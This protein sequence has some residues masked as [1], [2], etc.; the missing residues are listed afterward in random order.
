MR[1]KVLVL[2]LILSLVATLA[3]AG[4]GYKTGVFSDTESEV[5]SEV[6]EVISEIVPPQ[7]IKSETEGVDTVVPETPKPEP[8]DEKPKNDN[9]LDEKG[10]PRSKSTYLDDDGDTVA[11]LYDV[12]PGVDD[13]SDDCDTSAFTNNSP[14]TN[15]TEKLDKNGD[16]RS[17]SKYLDDDGD[18]IANF[19]DICPGVD[20]N[21]SSCNA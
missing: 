13:F 16:P 4:Y 1:R 9:E 14:A 12:C 18:T 5:D 10:D 2:F 7:P 8:A 19:Y 21:S 11:N 20:D 3:V 6:S 17:K 15:S